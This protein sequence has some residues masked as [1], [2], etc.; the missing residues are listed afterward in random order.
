[1]LQWDVRRG[2]V[3]WCL[4][5]V[6][7]CA[8]SSVSSS[9]SSVIDVSLELSSLW[10]DLSEVYPP[11]S[12]QRSYSSMYKQWTQ[13]TGDLVLDDRLRWKRFGTS[14]KLA[15]LESIEPDSTLR[16]RCEP[17]RNCGT[18]NNAA[19]L[20][21]VDDCGSIRLFDVRFASNWNSSNEVDRTYSTM[22]TL[23]F[24][25]HLTSRRRKRFAVTIKK[26]NKENGKKRKRHNR[27][28]MRN[29][30]IK[31]TIELLIS[32]CKIF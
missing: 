5:F 6:S 30:V 14:R 19:A 32:C 9:S 1:M 10:L 11:L 3:R 20:S 13:G 25:S 18:C 22:T 16:D 27:Y 29:C 21:S 7:M 26:R 15:T 4:S 31:I 2:M 12:S 17:N 23:K 8:D 24:V 28:I